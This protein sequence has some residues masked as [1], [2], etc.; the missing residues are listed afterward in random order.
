MLQLEGQLWTRLPMAHLQQAGE[1]AG[2]GTSLLFGHTICFFPS[3]GS[4]LSPLH[5]YC[6][7]PQLSHLVL[8]HHLQRHWLRSRENKT[9]SHPLF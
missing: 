3:V 1:E 5:F 9:S 2:Q 4:S 7:T 8:P 6:L